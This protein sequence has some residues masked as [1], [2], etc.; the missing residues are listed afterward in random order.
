[1]ATAKKTAN[2]KQTAPGAKT[3]VAV[4]PATNIVDITKQ[5]QAEVATLAD[6]T[7]PAGGDVIRITQDKQFQ[8]PDGRKTPGPINVVI[9]DFISAN[10]FWHGKYDPK[11]IEPPACFAI[12]QNPTTLVPSDNSPDK[13]AATCAV[14]PNNQFGSDGDGKACKNG[15]VLAVIPPDYQEGDALMLLKVSPT[16]LKPFDGYVRSVATQFKLPPIG[17]I[18]SVSLDPNQTYASLRFGDPRPTPPELLHTAAALREAARARLIQEPDVS[19]YETPSAK[20][21]PA[22][23]RANARR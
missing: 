8:L 7:S 1:M 9:V 17:V 20:S 5:L 22:A 12:G 21:K 4:K 6:R 15:R 16:A 18:T 13:Q 3:T 14:C 2:L 10:N 23:K 11:N 19:G